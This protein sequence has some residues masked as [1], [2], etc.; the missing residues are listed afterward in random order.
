MSV[1][2]M[3]GKY[4]TPWDYN[5]R[6]FCGLF[7]QSMFWFMY[8]VCFDLCTKY[9][10]IYVQ[11]MFWFMYKVCFDLYTKFVLICVQSL[12]WFMYKVCFDLCIKYVLFKVC[13][14]ALY[15]RYMRPCSQAFRCGLLS[16]PSRWM[17]MNWCPFQQQC[18]RLNS[19]I[20]WSAWFGYLLSIVI[21]FGN[22]LLPLF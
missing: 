11:S 6:F 12:F 1:L 21:G 2:V 17:C 14:N 3:S 22:P 16:F 5:T 4:N 15:C 19:S 9:V 7:L 18:L 8:K 20:Q 10:L 13:F